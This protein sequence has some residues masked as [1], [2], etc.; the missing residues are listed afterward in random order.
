VILDRRIQFQRLTITEDEFGAPVETW[1]DEPYAPQWA[2]WRDVTATER[3][4]AQQELATR[5]SAVIV[6]WF[7]GL[8]TAA[9]RIVYDGLLWDVTG[10]AERGE[11]GGAPAAPAAT[12]VTRKQYLELACQAQ[13]EAGI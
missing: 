3:F 12:R 1:V 4:R 7:P 2:H 8:N 6:R 9:W 11:A 5:T 10:I 13:A